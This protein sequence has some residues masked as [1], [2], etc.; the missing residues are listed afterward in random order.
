MIPMRDL[1]AVDIEG[2]SLARLQR[3]YED[4]R[5][6]AHLATMAALNDLLARKLPIVVHAGDWMYFLRAD[7][8]GRAAAQQRQAARARMGRDEADRQ[9]RGLHQHE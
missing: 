2:L 1:D 6:E 5:D 8:L 9:H 3:E 4:V 7:A